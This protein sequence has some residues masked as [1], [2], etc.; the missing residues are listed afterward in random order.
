MKHI[1]KRVIDDPRN[2]IATRQLAIKHAKRMRNGARTSKEKRDIDEIINRL[3]MEIQAIMDK[4]NETPDTDP[5]KQ[6]ETPQK[7]KKTPEEV[8]AI[9]DRLNKIQEQFDNL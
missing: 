6:N 9:L 7:P 2:N 8:K 1:E 5:D 3:E 4:V